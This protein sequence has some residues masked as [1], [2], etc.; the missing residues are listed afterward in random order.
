MSWFTKFI[1]SSLG[2]KL[3][4]SLT[5]LFLILFLCVHL[6][7]NMQLFK[8]DQGYAYNVFSHFMTHNPVIEAIAIL[9]YLFILL[10]AIQGIALWVQNRSARGGQNYAVKVTRTTNTNSFASR[11]MAYL[12]L[13][14]LVFLGIHMGDFWWKVKFGA[15]PVVM[16][17]GEEYQ[18]VFA[19]VGASFQIGWI[20]AIYVLAMVGLFFHLLHGFQ[21]AFQTLGIKHKK[22]TPV[23]R[24]LG[25]VYS[26][27]VPLLFASMPIYYFFFK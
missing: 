2:Q 23:I 3:V 24:F 22:Y 16:Y 8:G 26:I 15:P 9:L 13:L 10:H 20:V 17:D 11:N 4:M 6:Y 5:G 19:L 27:F 21:S 1:T 25:W 14:I 12:G 7:G 18:D